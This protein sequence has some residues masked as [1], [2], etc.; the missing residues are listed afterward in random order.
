M[1]SEEERK[2]RRR[3]IAWIM[4]AA[5]IIILIIMFVGQY[6]WFG[7]IVREGWFRDL[8]FG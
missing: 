2:K 4:L 1:E 5:L 8:L 7:K 6:L 3:K